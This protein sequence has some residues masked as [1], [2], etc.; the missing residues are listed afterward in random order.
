VAISSFTVHP[1]GIP[2]GPHPGTV[3]ASIGKEATAELAVMVDTFRPLQI[4]RQAMELDDPRYPYTWL[5]P[6]D[7]SGEARQLAERGPEAFPD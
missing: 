3:E 1:A 4:T 7:A 6:E 5:P 2:H